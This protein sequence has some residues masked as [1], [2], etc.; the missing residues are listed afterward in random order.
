LTTL[1]RGSSFCL[2]IHNGGPLNNQPYLAPCG[3]VPDQ[4]WSLTEENGRVK[5]KVQS[6]GLGQ[7]LDI[8]NGGPANNQPHLTSCANVTGQQW[9]L[10]RTQYP[11]VCIIGIP[12]SGSGFDAFYRKY[13]SVG[14]I[15]LL[16]SGAVADQAL[17]IAAGI[18]HD[19]LSGLPQVRAELIR[20]KVKIGVIGRNEGLTTLPEYREL[21]RDF[22][23]RNGELWNDRARGLGAT[24]AIPMTSGAEENLLCLAEDR[25][26][27]ESIFLHEFA[28]TIAKMGLMYT[29][30]TFDSR[31]KKIY[32][33]AMAAGLW[34]NTYAARDKDEYWAE[35]VQSYF[36]T[37]QEADPPNGIH[38]HVNT[39]VELRTYDR[40]LH[41]LV[42]SVFGNTRRP[43]VCP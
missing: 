16:A 21:D 27:G 25:Y 11:V 20:R 35:G 10:T 22:P 43:R 14:G 24:D 34:Q 7:C 30:A 1:F 31:L 9:V 4:L 12:P 37:N 2:D 17:E 26:R 36:D 38:N 13:C 8:F 41:D 15:P 40:S 23:L 19:L 28:H 32:E 42:H 3:N 29:D 39:R 33:E 18:A 5:L 6:R